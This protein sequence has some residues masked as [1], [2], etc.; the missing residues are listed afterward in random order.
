[1]DLFFRNRG[2]KEQN[3]K[4]EEIIQLSLANVSSNPYQPRKT[5]KEEQLQDLAESIKEYGVLQPVLVRRKGNRYELIAGER[6]LRAAEL[7]GLEKIP[8]IVRTF[9]DRDIALL[10]LVENLQREDLDYFEEA[11][12]YARLIGSFGLTQEEL[13]ER[14]GKSQSAIANKLRLLKLSDKIRADISREIMTERH[15]RALLKL[16]TEE[17]QSA[18]IKRVCAEKLNVKETELLIEEILSKNAGSLDEKIIPIKKNQKMLRIV[19]DMRIF[20]NAIKST[21]SA[22]R[23]AGVAATFEQ[24]E[25]SDYLELSIRVPVSESTTDK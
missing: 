17:E 11:E 22:M 8:A 20:L 14:L 1:M 7:A 5:F 10:A 12:G 18:V 9:D 13:A 19:K 15:A 21:V 4:N 3:E 2:A 16:N 24:R 25:M 23:E 6:R